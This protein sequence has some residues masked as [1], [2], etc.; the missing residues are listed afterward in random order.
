MSIPPSLV[1]F[2][3][4]T[5]P[6]ATELQALGMAFQGAMAVR[7]GANKDRKMHWFHAFALTTILAFGGGWLGFMLMGK[8]TSMVTG[9]DVNVTACVIAFV[10]VNYTPFDIGYKILNLLP[11]KVLIT[12]FAQ[13]FRSTGM[14]K[15]INTAYSEISPTPY[16]PIP[17]LGPIVYGT[18]LGN[19]GGLVMKGFDGYLKNGIPWPFQNGKMLLFCVLLRFLKSKLTCFLT[20][21]RYFHWILL[22][23]V[24]ARRG[25]HSRYLIENGI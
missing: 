19:M 18:M 20:Y 8:P 5:Y 10:T 13:L 9:G 25:G 24:C 21:R 16:Y 12:V 22:P 11:C 15:F 6:Y 17:V 2:L 23:L 14:I 3:T 7:A 4:A 1:S